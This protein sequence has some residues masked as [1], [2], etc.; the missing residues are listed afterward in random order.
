MLGLA[1]T[2]ASTD[3]GRA[4]RLI[5]AID[6]PGVR[7]GALVSLAKSVVSL[8]REWAERLVA[9]AQPLIDLIDDADRWVDETLVLAETLV[10][11]DPRG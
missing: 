6:D 11:L 10:H 7:A 4:E 9:R 5:A 2:L 8:D 1:N 3:A